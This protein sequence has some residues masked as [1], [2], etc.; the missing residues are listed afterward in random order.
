MKRPCL[1]MQWHYEA[2]GCAL[3]GHNSISDTHLPVFCVSVS[4]WFLIL[5]SLST[6]FEE[7][8]PTWP[9]FGFLSSLCA[10]ALSSQHIF[11]DTL[12]LSYIWTNRAWEIL[13]CGSGDGAQAL[14]HA[15][16]ELYSSCQLLKRRSRIDAVTQSLGG[17]RQDL[18][19]LIPWFFFVFPGTIRVSSLLKW[20]CIG[21][22][23]TSCFRYLDY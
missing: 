6:C 12:S 10:S 7:N 3:G 1:W 15:K 20:T 11:Q 18:L 13:L 17:W 4:N 9:C 2:L 23:F 5:S 22:S 8:R 14:G 21:I 19:F 16:K